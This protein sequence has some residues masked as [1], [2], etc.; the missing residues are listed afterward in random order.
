M[1]IKETKLKLENFIKNALELVNKF[2]KII[3]QDT[4]MTNI[5]NDFIDIKNE[6][7]FL[8]R[9]RIVVTG[10]NKAGKSCLINT[11]LES[12]ILYSDEE[13]ATEFILVI[14]PVNK[15]TPTL[16]KCNPNTIHLSDAREITYFEKVGNEPI[17]NGLYEV[18][19]LMK[20]INLKI[21][22][23]AN[24][25]LYYILECEIP[26]FKGLPAD[27]FNLIEIIDSPGRNNHKRSYFRRDM[28]PKLFSSLV[29]FIYVTKVD[30]Y[31]TDSDHE[32]FKHTLEESKRYGVLG[33]EQIFE[34]VVNQFDL[35]NYKTEEEQT[36][37]LTSIKNYFSKYF[38]NKEPLP[39]S[40][41]NELKRMSL[42]AFFR[43]KYLKFNN[44]NLTSC[45]SIYLKYQHL[46]VSDGIREEG[47][48]GVIGESGKTSEL[49]YIAD[50]YQ[51][52]GLSFQLLKKYSLI[53]EYE[54]K[55]RKVN[56]L[57]EL[58]LKNVNKLYEVLLLRIFERL[59]N[60]EESFNFSIG[61]IL[62]NKDTEL[63]KLD[64]ENVKT[65]SQKIEKKLKDYHNKLK[66]SI[67]LMHKDI[68]EEQ[69][70]IDLNNKTCPNDLQNDLKDYLNSVKETNTQYEDEVIRINEEFHSAFKFILE[71]FQAITNKAKIAIPENKEYC[72]KIDDT[73]LEFDLPESSFFVKISESIN[74]LFP[75]LTGLTGAGVLVGSASKSA[76]M[77]AFGF[78]MAVGAGFILCAAT[79]VY[80]A[81][82]IL[83]YFN[84]N[85]N[86]S[87]LKQQFEKVNAEIERDIKEQYFETEGLLVK[88]KRAVDKD[89]T[90]VID[91]ITRDRAV[92]LDNINSLNIIKADFSKGWNEL[93]NYI[94][95]NK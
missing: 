55:D 77:G 8:N 6:L 32:T 36:M 65:L 82:W 69:K 49:T 13:S 7:E 79:V 23:G 19:K 62:G 27:I 94:T 72:S 30:S 51:H 78:R 73:L 28:I 41:L 53:Y 75:T 84:D 66:E 90:S 45:F 44:E 64:I 87:L 24:E 17:A 57:Q 93:K 10:N 2:N 14:K 48:E 4:Q 60:I 70:V 12:E 1:N 67:D 86:I 46:M 71:E 89:V 95:N 88:I 39:Y 35:L 81:S 16:W 25:H 38:G 18:K 9:L 43:E 47:L 29:C 68:K 37:T 74:K 80:I 85:K 91:T 52:Y 56:P 61:L 15:E 5:Q 54:R 33:E 34:I 76:R 59:Y 50:T 92:I 3:P 26:I 21:R 40:S 42:E 58:L 20:E 83:K 31:E 11:I 22:E 63:N